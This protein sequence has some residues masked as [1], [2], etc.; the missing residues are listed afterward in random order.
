MTPYVRGGVK[1]QKKVDFGGIFLHALEVDLLTWS[2][3]NKKREQ[4]RS[5]QQR[6]PTPD[7][8]RR[9]VIVESLNYPRHQ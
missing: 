7:D 4:E 6:E 2:S 1:D 8:K 9:W 3:L 5:K